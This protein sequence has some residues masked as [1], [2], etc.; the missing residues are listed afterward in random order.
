MTMMERYRR[1][2]EALHPTEQAVEGALTGGAPRK[3][4][5]PLRAAIPAAVAVPLLTIVIFIPSYALS[6][7]LHKLPVVGRYL[8]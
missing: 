8:T 5:R 1:A 6:W 3:R 2:N 4:R 7:L